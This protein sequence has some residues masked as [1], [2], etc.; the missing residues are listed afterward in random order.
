MIQ[1]LWL[2]I[3]KICRVSKNDEEYN[4]SRKSNVLIVFDEMI[5]DMIINKK[6]SPIIA[7]LFSRGRKLNI[8]TVFI[9]SSYFKLPKDV[10]LI[11]TCFLLWKFQANKSF[12]K[13]YLFFRQILALK[14]YWIFKKMHCKIIFLLVIDTNLAPE[15]P[16]GF[17]RS[18]LE[19][20]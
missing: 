2:N 12:N 17:R 15:N 4:Q 3:Q 13:S 9:T 20:M 16:I 7:E 5:T 10:R 6:M 18:L 14:T 11:L 8:F 1:R 19:R